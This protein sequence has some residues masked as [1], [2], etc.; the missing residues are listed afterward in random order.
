MKQTQNQQAKDLYFGTHKSQTQIANEV[1]VSVKTLYL[2]IKKGA[3]D[4]LKMASLA[5]PAIIVDNL[6]FM[7][8]DLQKHIGERPEGNRFPTPQEVDSIRKLINSIEKMKHC[9]S[10]G[11]NMQ[12]MA[13]FV[14]YLQP[15]PE[16][17]Q[18]LQLHAE[19]YFKARKRNDRYPDHFAYGAQPP[20][21]AEEEVSAIKEEL[22]ARF[23]PTKQGSQLIQEPCENFPSRSEI[24]L[25]EEA[26]NEAGKPFQPTDTCSTEFPVQERT[27][28]FVPCSHDSGLF[29]DEQKISH[30]RP[31]ER[32]N[33]GVESIILPTPLIRYNSRLEVI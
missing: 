25:K 30:I 16:F 1:G 27:G 10:T 6:C 29:L 4:E 33:K 24:P 2:W 11:L 8:V 3:W 26:D 9:S 28:N 15:D 7:L 19:N 20:M 32:N 17:A 12:V 5:A 13:D 14:N 23:G 18:K 22:E 21:T 31:P